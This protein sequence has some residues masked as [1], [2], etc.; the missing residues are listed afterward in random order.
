MIIF[1]VLFHFFYSLNQTR[2]IETQPDYQLIFGD[3]VPTFEIE[4]DPEKTYLKTADLYYS[5]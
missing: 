5:E 4:I 2:R 1:Y 3:F